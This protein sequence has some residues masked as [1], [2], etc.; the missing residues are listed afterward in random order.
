MA[1]V[2]GGLLARY[3]APP[4]AYA[5]NQQSP[6]AEIRARSFVLVDLA[7]HPVGTF[8]T[9]TFGARNPAGYRIILRDPSG[10]IIWGAGGTGIHPATTER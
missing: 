3:I 9:E 1:G 4:S 8:T 5:Q 6:A 10:R 2:S 7:D